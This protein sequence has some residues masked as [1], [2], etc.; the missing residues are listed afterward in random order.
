MGFSLMFT[1][2]PPSS[3]V[4]SEWMLAG[5][6]CVEVDILQEVVAVWN[7]IEVPFGVLLALLPVVG[8]GEWASLKNR[9]VLYSEM[10]N[11]SFTSGH[12]CSSSILR[13]PVKVMNKEK[14]YSNSGGS[15]THNNEHTERAALTHN[16][17][18]RRRLRGM[19]CRAKD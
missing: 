12:L 11:E 6:D 8:L 15:P 16:K 19:N 5:V 10:L 7:I 9:M 14:P 1:T 13:R 2:P 18:Q 4:Q 17:T 3:P